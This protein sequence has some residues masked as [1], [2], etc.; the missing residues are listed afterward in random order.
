MT[1]PT[2]EPL[3]LRIRSA[4]MTTTTASTGVEYYTS[5]KVITLKAGTTNS[6]TTVAPQTIQIA[7]PT[8]IQTIT[9]D[10]NG[11]VPAGTCNALWDYYPSFG[12]ALVF[13]A[14]FGLLVIAHIWQA[15]AYKKKFCWV[16][17][18]AAIWE[19]VAFTFRTLSTRHQQNTTF[20]LIFQIFILL[21]PLWV[22][23]FDYMVLGRMIHFFIP[24]HSLFS[25]PASTLAVGFV[26]LDFVSFIIQLI[27]GSWAGP[28]APAAKQ[29]QGIH[30]YMGGIG[31][32]QFFILIFVGFGVKFQREM[33]ELE[34]RG[35]PAKKKWRGLL[36]TLYTTLGLI[37]VRIIFRLVQFSAGDTASNPLVS[38]EALFYILEAVP[39]VFAVLC[40]NIKHPGSV[41]VGP[42]SELPG[43][44]ATVM[45]AWR[46]RK[47]MEPLK[48]D[49]ELDDLVRSRENSRS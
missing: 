49:G 26:S 41:L 43:F 6:H 7:L 2:V 48:D 16:I 29:L 18:M 45:S 32:Q 30:I 14:L 35:V 11:H 3:D 8:C 42:D 38:S 39:M 13:S 46:R 28:T 47:G 5:T 4:A 17:T 9:P 12:A 44:F 34:R 27:G 31:L 22:N 19:T 10:K 25:I 33:L 20:Y 36:Y 21:A 24:S 40:F 1:R 23:A 15:A 37:T